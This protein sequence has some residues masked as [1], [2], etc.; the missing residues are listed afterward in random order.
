MAAN[1]RAIA[2]YA[3]HDMTDPTLAGRLAAATVPTLVLWG[4]SDR[5]VDPDY[6][7]AYAAAIPTATYQPLFETGHLP[8]L[9]TPAL[10]LD[11]IWDFAAKHTP[12]Q[13]SA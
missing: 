13:H 9:E 4:Q 8:Q 6:G 12:H 5:V 2:V 1:R 7:R 11:A 3:G 10:A